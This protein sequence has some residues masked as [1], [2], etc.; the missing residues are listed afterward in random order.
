[1]AAFSSRAITS[2]SCWKRARNC[3]SKVNCLGRTLIATWRLM[4][5]SCDRYTIAMP[6]CPS[7]RITS[8][9]PI[10]MNAFQSEF[11]CYRFAKNSDKT[12]LIYFS[13]LYNRLSSGLGSCRPKVLVVSLL[14]WHVGKFGNERCPVKYPKNAP[15]RK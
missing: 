8:Y 2:T 1:M 3:G 13:A 5:G 11:V 14:N 7:S 9:R 6:P 4:F 12:S 10:F 15:A